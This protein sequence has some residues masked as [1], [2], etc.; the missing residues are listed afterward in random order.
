M[1]S[2]K[3][4]ELYAQLGEAGAEDVICRAIEEL[5]VRLSHCERLWRQNDMANLRKSARSL[6]AISDQIG[7]TAMARIARDVTAA[8]DSEDPSAISATLFRLMRIGER[9]LTA[10]W[11]QQDLS[12]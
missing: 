3:L 2:E 8:I 5:A 6:I 12:V 10:V 4:S 11:E 7:M 9:S 1:D